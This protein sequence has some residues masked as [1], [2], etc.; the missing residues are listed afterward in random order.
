MSKSLV[1]YD[2]NSL[3]LRVSRSISTFKVCL[4]LVNTAKKTT[5]RTL[6]RLKCN[7]SEVL[8][9]TIYEGLLKAIFDRY[10]NYILY[11][12]FALLQKF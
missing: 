6:R 4:N 12:N 3:Y 8:E 5:D 9:S 7:L 11:V 1:K 2:K 10:E